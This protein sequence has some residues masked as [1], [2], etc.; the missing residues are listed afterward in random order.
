MSDAI[1]VALI[2]GAVSLLG[3]VMSAVVSARK[4]KQQT[5]LTLY[6]IDELEQK[7]SKHNG[8]I[9]RTYKLEGRMTEA[10]HDIRDLKNRKGA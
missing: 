3:S 5:D 9:E 10:E 4:T 8:V 7:V 6:R 1:I 2:T